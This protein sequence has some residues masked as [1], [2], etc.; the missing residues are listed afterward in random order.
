VDE[1]SR[2]MYVFGLIKEGTGELPAFIPPA[3]EFIPEVS[4]E[5]PV[6]QEPEVIEEAV[7]P[8]EAG[9]GVDVEVVFP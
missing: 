4:I 5:P 1:L 3:P 6:N 8:E 7:T 9:G 2:E